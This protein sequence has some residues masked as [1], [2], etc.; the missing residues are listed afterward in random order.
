[1]PLDET[2]RG[3]TVMNATRTDP[4]PQEQ[5]QSGTYAPP[6]APRMSGVYGRVTMAVSI[7]QTIAVRIDHLAEEIIS[8]PKALRRTLPDVAAEVIELCG[9]SNASAETMER[10]L[11]RD[12]FISAQVVSVANSAMFAPRMPILGVRDAVVRIGLDAVRDVVMMVVANSTMFRVPGL[13]AEVEGMRKRMLAS[14]SVA[15]LLARALGAESEYGFLAGLLHDIGTLVLLERA[16][17]EGIVT[18]AIWAAPEGDLVRERIHAHHT[19]A[20]GAI[21]RSW[22]LPSGVV[23]AALFHHDY[24]SG[25]KTHLAAHL[26]AAADVAA[27]YILP[28]A[29]PPGILLSEQPVLIELG[30]APGVIENLV[31]RARPA[32][33]ALISS[34]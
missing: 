32:A 20:G 23:D 18:P 34:R 7:G 10:T 19:A 33:L 13:A 25:G 12:P 29:E 30:L 1:M 14:A 4:P 17:H 21:C 26:V 31:E 9:R 28:D 11:T 16:V 15:R 3:S 8:D 24:R 6:V 22:K 5:R 2:Q 27:Q